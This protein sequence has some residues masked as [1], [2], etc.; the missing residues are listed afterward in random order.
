MTEADWF[1]C[2]A[3][4]PMLAFLGDRVSARKLRLFAV[5]CCR[6]ISTLRNDEPSR[7]GAE[8]AER[9]ADGGASDQELQQAHTAAVHSPAAGAAAGWQAPNPVAAATARVVNAVEAALG[10]ET[11]AAMD[12]HDRWREAQIQMWDETIDEASIWL[13]ATSAKERER[14]V[15]AFLLRDLLGNPFRASIIEPAWLTGNNK[16]VRK[17]A[18]EVYHQRAFDRLPSLADALARAGC[19]SADVLAHCRQPDEHVRGCWVVDLLL[20]KR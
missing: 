15:Q 14:K 11:L 13:A 16:A 4:E 17:L 3:P 8:V 19:T 2:N 1:D 7:N 20:G 12:A 6:R 18:E 5:A 10:T 9:Y